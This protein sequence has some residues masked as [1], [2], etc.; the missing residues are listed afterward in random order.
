[1]WIHAAAQQQ[2]FPVGTAVVCPFLCGQGVTQSAYETLRMTGFG[3]LRHLML[4][5]LLLMMPCRCWV[6]FLSACQAV[7]TRT[8]PSSS[9]LAPYRG[10]L[11][12]TATPTARAGMQ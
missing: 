9:L 7:P 3:M 12:R 2:S 10:W 8:L 6:P 11:G 4:T 1:M 5:A